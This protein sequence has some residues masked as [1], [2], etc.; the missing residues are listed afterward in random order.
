[1]SE[2]IPYGKQNINQDDINSVIEVLRSDFITQGETVPKFE[3]SIASHCDVKYAVA[4]NSATSSLHIAC[5]ALGV[6]VGDTV[7][8]S[9]NSFVAS[10]NCALYCGAKVDFVDIDSNTFNMSVDFLEEKLIKAAKENCLPKVV[11]PVHIAG[12]SCEMDRIFDLSKKYNFSIIEDASHAIGAKYKGRP[13]GACDYSDITVFSFHPVKII[14][15]AEGGM[16][17]TNNKDL[18]DKMN[19]LRS[20]GITRDREIMAKDDGPWYYEQHILG[21][22]YRMT[23]MQAALGLSQLNRI[24]EFV[25]KRRIIAETYKAELVNLPIRLPKSNSGSS[26]HLYIIQLKEE[27]IDRKN[28]FNRL[29]E[30]GIGVNVHY[31][32][33]YLNPYYAK[34]GF[35]KGLCFQA[36][37][38]YKNC[39]SIPI[40][41][42]LSGEEQGKVIESIK[43]IFT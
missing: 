29:R 26:W 39:I 30:K 12:Q 10:S 35:K 6:G 41:H 3:E 38:Y 33:I 17:T 21:F 28:I 14:T 19:R 40:F 13:V 15:T 34:L 23:E 16:A 2:F 7:W 22:N 36:E 24:N 43:G 18:F 9:P 1:M 27:S 32:P 11:I 37:E 25:D 4:A 20:H 31:R 8:T 42:T 5:L